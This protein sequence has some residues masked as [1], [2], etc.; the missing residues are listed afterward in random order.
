MRQPESSYARENT[1]RDDETSA[2]FA[3]PYV[4][5]CSRQ[6]SHWSETRSIGPI[7]EQPRSWATTES[8]RSPTVPVWPRNEVR[9]GCAGI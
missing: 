9:V 8:T 5:C 2:T 7:S 3:L 4:P 6:L 1:L